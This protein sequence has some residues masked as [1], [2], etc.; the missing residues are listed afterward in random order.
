M[1]LVITKDAA[2]EVRAPLKMSLGA[3]RRF[4]AE[5]EA[6]I[7]KKKVLAKKRHVLPRKFEEGEEFV[8]EGDAYILQISDCEEINISGLFL[9]FPKKFLLQEEHYL[10]IWY[11][12]RAL[13]KIIE[14]CNYYANKTQLKYMAIRISSAESCW[15]SCSHKGFLNINWRLIMAPPGVLDY[16]IVHELVHLVEKNHSKRFW[17][18]LQIILPDYQEQ[19]RWLKQYGN[20]LL[21]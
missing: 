6:W 13:E 5:N 3:I 14:R 18:K 9:H 17:D 4:V 10:T 19:E 16:I 11:K 7:E 21:V 20:T 2:L 12:R 15:G 8:Y 1:A